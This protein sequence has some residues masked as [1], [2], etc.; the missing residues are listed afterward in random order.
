MFPVHLELKLAG[1]RALVSMD[2]MRFC[3]IRNYIGHKANQNQKPRDLNVSMKNAVVLHSNGRPEPKD[4][5]ESH[6]I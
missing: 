5:V 1:C 6:R 2:P 4:N 3:G